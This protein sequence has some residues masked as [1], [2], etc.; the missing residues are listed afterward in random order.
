MLE[1]Y[2]RQ[3]KNALETV[4]NDILKD[5]LY[6]LIRAMKYNT[7][8]YTFGNGGSASIAD[9]WSCDHS[10]GV[11]QDASL[12]P[13]VDCLSNNMSLITAIANDISYD[14]IFSK[15][16]EMSDDISS[17]AIAISSSGSSKNI[18]RGLEAA[19]NK[20]W[21]TIAFVGFDGGTILKQDLADYI[22][23]VPYNNYGIVEDTHQ[24]IMHA[25][26]QEIRISNAR[27]GA[28]LKL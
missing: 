1:R 22:I 2:T 16:I 23:H 11:R 19:R 10:K 9:H 24:I 4:D 5:V 12:S 25:L 13:R 3:L 8:I 21:V 7:K 20:G 28:T 27:S 14:E 18:I 15:Q 17:V 26:A 6:E